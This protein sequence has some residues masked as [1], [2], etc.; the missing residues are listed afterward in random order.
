MSY[1]LVC[2]AM[3]RRL[4]QMQL[5]HLLRTSGWRCWN[6]RCQAS[7]L[8]RKLILPNEGIR[9]VNL[10]NYMFMLLHVTADRSLK[11]TIRGV[12]QESLNNIIL[13]PAFYPFYLPLELHPTPNTSCGK[14]REAYLLHPG[15]TLEQ[16]GTSRRNERW[17]FTFIS[18]SVAYISFIYISVFMLLLLVKH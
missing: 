13:F 12:P 2:H 18:F 8:T 6:F 11:L 15:Q 1:W 4:V 14:A 9:V 10:R 3:N 16:S 5:M 7:K 17:L